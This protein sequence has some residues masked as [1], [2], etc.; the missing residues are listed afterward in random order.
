MKL[1]FVVIATLGLALGASFSS[2]ETSRRFSAVVDSTF[3]R[4]Q[5]SEYLTAEVATGHIR[6]TISVTGSYSTICPPALS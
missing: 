6:R 5:M 3:G 1:L 4:A 2:E